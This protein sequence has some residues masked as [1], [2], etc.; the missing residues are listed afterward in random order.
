MNW[1]SFGIELLNF[2]TQKLL[3]KDYSYCRKN[4]KCLKLLHILN[5]IFLIYDC[6]WSATETKLSRVIHNTHTYT[7]QNRTNKNICHVSKEKKVA[8][9][10]YS[11]Y[12][13]VQY[14]IVNSGPSLLYSTDIDIS[15]N[16]T[17][18]LLKHINMFYGSKCLTY[19][20]SML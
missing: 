6:P 9:F 7:H 13:S 4:V 18:F 20:I 3:K 12:L 10:D 15:L 11:N 1:M 14:T 8:G 2:I 5:Y 16:Q 17:I 19:F